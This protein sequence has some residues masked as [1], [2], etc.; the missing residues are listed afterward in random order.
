VGPR[1]ESEQRGGTSDADQKTSVV[2]RETDD[3]SL[4]VKVGHP[5]KSEDDKTALVHDRAM[6]ERAGNS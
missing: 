4:R 2:D 6:R 3:R 1:R 5:E